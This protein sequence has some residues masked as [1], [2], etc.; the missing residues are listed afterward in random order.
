[1]ALSIIIP[2]SAKHKVSFNVRNRRPMEHY[3]QALDSRTGKSYVIPIDGDHIKAADIAQ[4][5]VPEAKADNGDTLSRSLRILDNGFQHTA[6]MES[7]I[8]FM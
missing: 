8:T 2:Y 6:C 4:I 7:S 1:M 3:L 5:T